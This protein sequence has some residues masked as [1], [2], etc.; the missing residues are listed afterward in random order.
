ML[1]KGR[2]SSGSVV[3]R[4]GCSNAVVVADKLGLSTTRS[5]SI[6]EVHAEELDT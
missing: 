3:G 6:G 5:F 2:Q 4:A 1:F